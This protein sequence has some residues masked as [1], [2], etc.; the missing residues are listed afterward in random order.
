[1]QN[2]EEIK[3]IINYHLPQLKQKFGI[4]EIGLFGS[5]ARG[6]Q[7]EYSDIDVLIEFEEGKKS[8]DNYMDLKF[9]LEELFGVKIDLVIK[10]SI[11]PKLRN[12]I[13]R[14]IIYV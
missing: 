14:D 1:M 8:F 9:Y 7:T 10:S 12:H 3:E 5:Y 13:L 11:R 6:E 2:V 4:K